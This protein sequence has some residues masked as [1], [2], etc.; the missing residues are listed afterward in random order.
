[1]NPKS[2]PSM[3]Q[4][5]LGELLATRFSEGETR[6]A[7]ANTQ[8][9]QIVQRSEAAKANRRSSIPASPSDRQ[10]G[11]PGS[12]VCGCCSAAALLGLQVSHKL[13]LG[14]NGVWWSEETE[15]D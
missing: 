5:Y 10:D 2:H 12:G 3:N 14:S 15:L 4:P 11:K 6:R 1:M 7:G 9:T 13:V 8:A